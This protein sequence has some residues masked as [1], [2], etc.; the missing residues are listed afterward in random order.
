MV[1]PRDQP[2]DVVV[3][4]GTGPNRDA[5]RATSFCNDAGRSLACGTAAWET[6]TG[7]TGMP[8]AQGDLH[9]QTHEV[10]GIVEPALALLVPGVERG[11]ADDDQ[12]HAGLAEHLPDVDGKGDADRNA[13]H[14]LEDILLREAGDQSVVMRPV[15]SWLS[16]RR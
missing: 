14:V 7:T 13:I 4:I 1:D 15:T 9:L 12:H 11:G 10:V 6:S 16:D 5:V 2:G 8:A 3:E